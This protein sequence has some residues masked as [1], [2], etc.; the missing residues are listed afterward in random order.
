MSHAPNS[1][2]ASDA[3][4]KVAFLSQLD[5]DTLHE[6]AARARRQHFSPGQRIVSELE[7]GADVFVLTDGS[8]EICLDSGTSERQVLGT[9][10][11]FAAVGEMSSLTGQL[12]SATVTALSEVDTLVIADADFD[13]LRER[14]PE[15]AIALIRVLAH[16]L[17]DAERS[18]DALLSPADNAEQRRAA[19]ETATAGARPKLRRGSITRAFREVVAH[20]QRDLPFLTLTAF[21][22][23]LVLIR[24]IIY[25]SFRFDVSP[26]LV[27]RAAYISGFALLLSSSLAALLT[28]RPSI[29][30]VIALSY[31]VGC[32]LIFNELGV[33][34]AF[35]IFYT[36]VRTP[37]PNVPF[38]IEL[39]YR[40]TEGVRAIAIGLVVLIQA[41]FL[42]PFYRRALFVLTTRLRK[43]VS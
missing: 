34:L 11:P 9:I 21:A 43:R 38:D 25:A 16:R 2:Q 1:K 24:A 13:R 27:L 35:D 42:R 31:G 33:T 36:D 20:H 12:R 4:R 3:L 8:A 28:F 32:A 6:L 26:R 15:V 17:A 29:R 10:G 40:R 41:A 37:D 5:D 39:L 14:R 30:R 7:F 19:I 22:V 23:T 18:I